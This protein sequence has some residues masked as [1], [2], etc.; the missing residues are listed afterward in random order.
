MLEYGVTAKR[1]DAHG[2]AARC[3]GAEI[4][5]DTDINGRTDAFNPAELFLAGLLRRWLPYYS[6]AIIVFALSMDRQL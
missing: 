5:L 4:V 3:K 2:S 1:I 6:T